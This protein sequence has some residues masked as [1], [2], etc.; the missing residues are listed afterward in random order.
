MATKVNE[1]ELKSELA[2]I[3][4]RYI[5]NHLDKTFHEEAMRLHERYMHLV[6]HGLV[7][8][9]AETAISNLIEIVQY[10][11]GTINDKEMLKYAREVLPVLK[12]R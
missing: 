4:E 6:G 9:E 10:G 12:R 8:N 3:Y 1:T 5:K 7:S 2:N 11:K